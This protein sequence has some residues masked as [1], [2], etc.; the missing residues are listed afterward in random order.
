MPLGWLPLAFGGRDELIDD[1]LRAVGEI[2]ELRLPADQHVPGEERIAVIKAQHGGFT[3]QAVVGAEARLVR[4]QMLQRTE[5]LA[6][7][8]VIEKLWR[9][10]NVPRRLSWPL[11]RTPMPS[12]SSVAKA[13]CSACAQSNGPPSSVALRAAVQHSGF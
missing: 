11:K 12:A 9:C 8:E 3:E 10:E 13:R 5:S 7:F 4:R 6:C 1:H 2:A